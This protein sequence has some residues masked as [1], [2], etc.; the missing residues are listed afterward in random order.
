MLSDNRLKL[1]KS[2]TR[3]MTGYTPSMKTRKHTNGWLKGLLR[4][5]EKILKFPELN[6]NE[7]TPYENLWNLGE[8]TLRR[9]SI[10]IKSCIW[11]IREHR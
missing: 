5:Q 11:K 9:K 7:N 4:N 2:I 10:P 3:E 1:K 8:P 6:E